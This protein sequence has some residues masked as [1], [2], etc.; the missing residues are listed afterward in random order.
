MVG[1]ELK[2]FS[3]MIRFSTTEAN[4]YR[5]FFQ[6]CGERISRLSNYAKVGIYQENSKLIIWKRIE[7]SR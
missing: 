4:S 7:N 5:H 2:T 1:L 3:N 6:Q